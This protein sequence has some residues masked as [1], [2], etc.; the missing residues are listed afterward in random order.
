MTPAGPKLL[1]VENLR[2][3]FGHDGAGVQAVRGLNLEI[4]SG[5]VVALVGESG[6]GKSMTA[7]AMLRLLPSAAVATG[8]IVYAGRDL[9]ALSAREMRDIR[10]PEIAMVFQEPMTSLNPAFT[11]GDQ[12]AEP[13]RH[14]LG[15]SR[16]EAW[17]K[18]EELLAKVRIPSPGER[19][20]CYPHQLSGGMRQR[21][22]LAMA[23]SCDP[24][25]LVLD[26]PTTALDVTTQA[27]I[28]EVVRESCL[29]RKM[30]VLL[31]THDL[32]V[33]AD[34]ADRVVV[35]YAGVAI[36]QAST[37]SLFDAP[38]HPYT[39]GLLGA[40]PKR[41]SSEDDRPKKL[42]EIPGSVPVLRRDPVGCAFAARCFAARGD[43]LQAE[44]TLKAIAV[45]HLSACWHPV[46][47]PLAV[48]Q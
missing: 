34:L 18:A 4:G 21:V 31:I 48:D 38:V 36:E 25:L 33:V 3:I 27:E 22:M 37:W 12:V 23:L 19:A 10:G 6:C 13:L 11:V 24:K 29:E 15:I 5:E 7:L 14:H 39:R 40:L 20:R 26:E 2:V 45:D 30:S 43:C 28:L 46:R 8:R 16:R 47:T 32:G 42:V 9:F 1:S 17:S 41:G 35:M 44:P